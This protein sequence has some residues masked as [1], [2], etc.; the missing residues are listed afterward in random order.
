MEAEQ[1]NL[2]LSKNLIEAARKYAEIYGYKNMQ[3]LAAES[4]REKVFENNEFDETL[5]DKE[6]ELIDSLI[7]L[8]IKKDD[9][10][11][12]EELKKTLLE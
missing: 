10:V 4:I 9:L 3:E 1:I 7:G 2:K 5:S 8:S 12:E 6:I 11:S